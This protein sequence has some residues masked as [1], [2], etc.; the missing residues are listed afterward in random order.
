MRGKLAI[1]LAI[2]AMMLAGAVCTLGTASAHEGD[3]Y[4]LEFDGYSKEAEL[5]GSVT[6]TWEIYNNGTTPVFINTASA[7]SDPRWS[8]SPSPGFATLN[9]GQS[10]MVNMTV[11]APSSRDYAT[12]TAT[13]S[14]VF[15]DLVTRETWTRNYTVSNGL[16]G[17]ALEPEKKIFGLFENPI[18]FTPLD[19]NIEVFILDIV[20]TI[21][22]ALILTFGTPKLKALT[23][24]TETEL[25]DMII[26]I[27][28]GPISAIILLHGIVAAL[29]ALD[30]PYDTVVTIDKGYHI[31]LILLITW[32]GY[33]IF[34]DVV[35][36][37][38]KIYAEK[39]ETEL[40]DVL[41]PLLEKVG[42]IAILV[43]GAIYIMSD[44]GI[45]LT[46][47]IAGFGVMGVVIGLA[48]QQTLGNLI[49]GMFLL[50][51][52]PF[53]IGDTIRLDNGD[54]CKVL[55]VGLRT[56]KLYRGSTHDIIVVP[57]SDIANKMVINVMQPDAKAQT[58]VKVGVAYG[59][60]VEKVKA[61]LKDIAL[62][63]E[64]VLK[65]GEHAPVV[66]F[67]N[68][69]DSSLD[70]TLFFWVDDVNAQWA[71]QSDLRERIN[72]A[73]S[74]KGI[75]IP[76]PQRVLRV[77]RDDIETLKR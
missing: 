39:S 45:D 11:T 59:T 77:Q 29:E 12:S 52:R 13:L 75:E 51:D 28:A 46:L 76:F 5:G 36:Y 43:V 26:E 64:H 33:K 15:T 72:K 48:M 55:E 44:F 66:R 53:K 74:E 17:G 60:D 14:V 30:L 18:K 34:K 7:I 35:V 31:I 8:A 4:V 20:I 22:L 73:F 2:A 42:A 1:T 16:V 57:N 68:F 32:M 61:L 71:A 62:S 70:F 65:D 24:K 69:G 6:Y 56:T 63:H 27:V 54:Y 49:S 47:L 41:I 50:T 40:D 25:D 23:K 9:A 38:A 58:S 37:Y 3:V 67:S 10:G 21:I 19:Q